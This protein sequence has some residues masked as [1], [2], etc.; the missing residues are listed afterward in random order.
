MSGWRNDHDFYSLSLMR[1]DYGY[2]LILK[3]K[4]EGMNIASSNDAK[5]IINVRDSLSKLW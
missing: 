5:E 1:H 2:W 4:T 3:C